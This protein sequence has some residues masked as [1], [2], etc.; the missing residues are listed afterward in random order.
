M[1]C[2]KG[3][4]SV[5]FAI[6]GGLFFTMLIGAME[7]GRLFFTQESLREVTAAAARRAMVDSGLAGC[8]APA[9]AVAAMTPFLRPDALTLCVSRTVSA[10][11]TTL[12]V[13]AAYPFRTVIPLL[14]LDGNQLTDR[15]SVTF[16]DG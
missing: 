5:E 15:M 12:T 13:N 2:R 10:G 8:I 7:A 11:Q 14:A 6:V 9:A 4:T 1:R 3:A 16:K